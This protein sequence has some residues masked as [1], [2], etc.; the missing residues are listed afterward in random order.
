MKGSKST[1]IYARHK[2]THALL[3]GLHW[4][5]LDIASALDSETSCKGLPTAGDHMAGSYTSN[6]PHEDRKSS[7]IKFHWHIPLIGLILSW[8]KTFAKL[9]LCAS[10]ECHR[11]FCPAKLGITHNCD[12]LL[13]DSSANIHQISPE[14]AY[15]TW[16]CMHPSESLPKR[17]GICQQVSSVRSYFSENNLWQTINVLKLVCSHGKLS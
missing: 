16:I 17:S 15:S 1:T 14:H 9:P 10:V 3:Q 12:S 4:S 7:E 11:R 6:K 2:H 13:C 5:Y 8:Y